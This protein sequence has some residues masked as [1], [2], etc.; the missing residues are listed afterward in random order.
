MPLSS[1]G[2]KILSSMKSEYGS[3]KG[4]QVFYASKNAGRIS[5]IDSY[6]DPT[7][8]RSDFT[9][10]KDNPNHPHAT[11]GTEP[12]WDVL[13]ARVDAFCSRCD[14]LAQFFREEAKEPEHKSGSASTLANAAFK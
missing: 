12:V 10:G 4:E 13:A 6:Y 9:I 7:A 2:E 3:K 8:E 5:G 1:K 14:A 11:T